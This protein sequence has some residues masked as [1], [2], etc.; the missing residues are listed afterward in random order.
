MKKKRN[1]IWRA[2]S[3]FLVS[4]LVVTSMPV[5]AEEEFDD[6]C[7]SDENEIQQ[8]FSSGNI[9]DNFQ[10][11]EQNNDSATEEIRYIKGRPLTQEEK[12]EQL[13]PFDTLV[14][15]D[16]G[17]EIESYLDESGVAAY[18]SGRSSYPETFDM[19]ELN[20]VTPAKNQNPYGNC[21][22]FG[23]AA[24]METSLMAQ[25]KGI[26]DLSEEHLSYFF[27]HRQND[28]LNNTPDDVNSVAGNYRNAG[29][30]DMLASIFLSTWSGM[31][32]EEDVPLPSDSIPAEKAY[33]TEA[34]LKNAY[35]FNYSQ[36]K[37]K[38]MLM[39]NHAVSVMLSMNK[40]FYYNPDTAAYCYPS[41]AFDGDNHIVTIVGWDDNYSRNNFL[42]RSNVSS[43]GAWIAKNSWGSEWGDNGFFYISYES[44]ELRNLVAV[45]AVNSIKYGN[46]YFYDG[47]SATT[48]IILAADQSVAAIFDAR[49]G[50]G[51]AETLGEINITS[52]SDPALY[53]IQ[54]YAN[55]KDPSD[56]SSG[57]PVYSS[58]V[59][60][61]QS[62]A[63][64]RTIALPEVTLLQ[65]TKFSVVIKNKGK[66]EIS[67]GVEHGASYGWFTAFA[68]IEKGQ[69]FFKGKTSQTWT[70][71]YTKSW[72]ARIKA[73]TKTQS[74]PVT[75][76][77]SANPDKTTL[78]IGETSCMNAQ[79]TPSSVKYIGLSYQSSDKSVASVDDNGQITAR[80]PGTA[81]ITCH[82]T[83]STGLTKKVTVTVNP[84]RQLATPKFKVSVS[85]NGY[86]TITWKKV[87][88]AQWYTVWRKP[89][90]GGKWTRL[91]DVKASVL[92]YKDSKVTA[93]ESYCYTVRAYQKAG[94]KT[95]SSKYVP[96]DVVKAAPARQ[97]VA[98]IKT[99]PAGIRISWKPQKN[100]DGYRVYRKTK[101]GSYKILK[102]F[103]K[104]TYETYLDKTAK[105][106]VLYYYAVRAYV[107]GT[108]GVVLSKYTESSV[109]K[110]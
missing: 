78:N 52:L 80:N 97:R 56:P 53:E 23:M 40:G 105:K 69:T 86:N 7:F 2:V 38:E 50:K 104:G 68:G 36:E 27:S 47:S 24:I 46:N 25:N 8:E 82:S 43:D 22:A 10:D 58:P 91:G 74:S 55:V 48:K 57:S 9:Q 41:G 15:L 93:N 76:K 45:D 100:C 5:M 16:P 88:G 37:I 96:G 72:T 1:R 79:V 20:Y 108:D 83:D 101:N 77:L 61:Y 106:G 33:R 71:A 84:P 49:A 26:Y 4:A 39:E 103:S 31:T 63:G 18:S 59:Q 62:I 34:Y 87:S 66:N 94:D 29:G 65:N 70:D 89:G 99:G 73:H 110:R 95:Y 67:L 21:W 107:K 102:I 30:N 75:P 32:T 28:P 14:P 51:K 109:V 11:E 44:T 98:S 3:L 90:K 85:L 60:Y 13:A 64:V 35:F 17:P 92:R 42:D 12:E 19:R 81:V 54:V 6:G